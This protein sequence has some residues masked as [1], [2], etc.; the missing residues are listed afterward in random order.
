M[1]RHAR[2]VS[3]IVLNVSVFLL[4]LSTVFESSCY[5]Q[6]GGVPAGGARFRLVR[7]VSGSKGTPQ[8]GIFA[9]ED[10]RSVFYIPN[11][12]QVIVYMEWEGPT[13]KHHIEGFWRNPAGKITVISD[14]D[15]DAKDQKFGGYWILALSE[16]MDTGG[17]ILEAH[18]DGELAGSHA[19]QILSGTR[20]PDSPP[21]RPLLA[22]SELYEH[23]L[24]S[25]VSIERFDRTGQK[26]GDASGFL[27]EPGWILTSF[28]CIDGAEKLWVTYSDGSR[29]ETEQLTAWNRR[30]DWALL[31]ATTT[32]LPKLKPAATN[33]WKVGDVASFLDAA[34]EG[35]RIITN[36][37][38]D[39]K[40]TFPAAGP[41]INISAAP[42]DRA[43]GA[44]LLN[45]YGEVVA[46]VGG[47][48]IPGARSDSLFETSSLP[49][50]G[51]SVY[52]KGGLA[53]PISAVSLPSLDLAGTPLATLAARGELLL[54]LTASRDVTYGKLARS[55]DTKSGS[56]FPLE[57]G[58]VFS[59]RDPKLAVYVLWEGREKIKGQVTMRIYTLDNQLLN[60]PMVEKPLKFS[61]NQ[62]ERRAT[63]WDVEISKLPPGIYRVDVWLDDAP[64]WRTFFRLT[65]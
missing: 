32:K 17:W 50:A 58:D 40:N 18:V 1:K 44:S 28:E 46:I 60:K 52:L 5:P 57:S 7:S 3:G 8:G 61:L 14:F 23:A 42:T 53:V 56:P 12:H 48:L 59:K 49:R 39:G 34:P 21:A 20:S 37:S 30:Q 62:A 43:I 31:K 16:S 11:D 26:F 38:I 36:V 13:G 65:E 64:A 10:P 35:N 25:T 4:L 24:K 45:E 27:F 54:P 51:S 41:R 15:Y 19:F 22:P 47:S 9:M 2:S 63:S 6:G 33:S 29:F 55:I